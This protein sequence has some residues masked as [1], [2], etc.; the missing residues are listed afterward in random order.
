M[1]NLYPFSF[2]TVRSTKITTAMEGFAAG[3]KVLLSAVSEMATD[4]KSDKAAFILF[5]MEEFGLDGY[6]I[7]SPDEKHGCRIEP[8]EA[9]LRRFFAA[10][11]AK[12]LTTAT[13]FRSEADKCG[14]V[15]RQAWEGMGE[16]IIEMATTPATKAA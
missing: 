14:I 16:A 6:L 5:W 1:S 13:K 2:N 9:L 11:K 3:R 8:T 7:L 15:D 4:D 10:A 12:G